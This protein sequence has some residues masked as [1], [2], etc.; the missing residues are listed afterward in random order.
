MI[1]LHP[2]FYT[3]IRDVIE[4]RDAV[5]TCDLPGYFLQT[6]TEGDILLRINES[7]LALLLLV[8]LDYVQAL[9]ET[10]SIQGQES[11]DIRQM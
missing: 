3:L 7:F 2:K 6:D 10:P 4:G 11:S 9:E 5:A 8:K 1:I